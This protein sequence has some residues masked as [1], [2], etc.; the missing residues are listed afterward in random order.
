MERANAVLD[1]DWQ[2]LQGFFETAELVEFAPVVRLKRWTPS[3][4]RSTR[5]P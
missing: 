4:P 1:G 3:I 2:P 5:T